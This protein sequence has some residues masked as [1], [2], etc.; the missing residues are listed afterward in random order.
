[1]PDSISFYRA[2]GLDPNQVLEHCFNYK[3]CKVLLFDRLPM[4]RDHARTED[5]RTADFLDYWLE[6]DYQAIGHDV[7]RVPLIGVQERVEFVLNSLREDG[8]LIN[9]IIFFQT[10]TL[11]CVSIHKL[12]CLYWIQVS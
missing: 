1:M 6:K 3:Y 4:Q 9:V 12:D 2:A 8:P 11:L 5:D 7:I 10:T